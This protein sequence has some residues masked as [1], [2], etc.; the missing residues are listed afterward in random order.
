[1]ELQR[2]PVDLFGL[3]DLLPEARMDAPDHTDPG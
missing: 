2:S 1:M 3:L